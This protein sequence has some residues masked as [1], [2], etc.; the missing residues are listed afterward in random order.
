MLWC[1]RSGV[2][3]VTRFGNLPDPCSVTWAPAS[4]ALTPSV[5]WSSNCVVGIMSAASMCKVYRPQHAIVSDEAD[6]QPKRTEHV[7]R[8]AIASLGT[9]EI[10]SRAPSTDRI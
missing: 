8:V 10:S 6:C 2:D 1:L 3:S 5:L 9:W 4:L 7:Q